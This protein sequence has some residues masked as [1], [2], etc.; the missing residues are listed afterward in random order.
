MSLKQNPIL[1]E[2]FLKEYGSEDEFNNAPEYYLKAVYNTTNF[3]FYWTQKLITENQDEIKR[4][5]EPISDKR[6]IQKASALIANRIE[7]KIE[8]F[9]YLARLFQEKVTTNN[10]NIP[11]ELMEDKSGNYYHTSPMSV[12]VENL[13]NKIEEGKVKVE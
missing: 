6:V 8:T 10:P 5:E 4:L 1:K 3:T 12:F 7:R 2:Y 11:C 13:F 9:D